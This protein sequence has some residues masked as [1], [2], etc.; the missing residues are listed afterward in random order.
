MIE[1]MNQK[2]FQQCGLC[3]QQSLRP[4]GAYAQSDQGL[5]FSLEYSMTVKLLSE[6]HL[7][8][9]SLKGGCAQARLSIHL[10]KCHI[11][12]NH[13]SQLKNIYLFC[14]SVR[15]HGHGVFDSREHL[16]CDVMYIR[17]S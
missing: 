12:G 2:N 7:G 6:H 8:F 4:A 14:R 16:V 3:D 13:M 10:T 15:Q 17:E 11:V 9:L 1:K 5:C